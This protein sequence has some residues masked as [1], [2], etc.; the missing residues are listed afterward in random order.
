MWR[1]VYNLNLK[2]KNEKI[3]DYKNFPGKARG[4][5]WIEKAQEL[6]VSITTRS[7][8]GSRRRFKSLC[9]SSSQVVH[10]FI[11]YLKGN[12]VFI[13]FTWVT[14]R[15]VQRQSLHLEWRLTT[16]YDRPPAVNASEGKGLEKNNPGF[17]FE[18]G[19]RGVG[20]TRCVNWPAAA[21]MLVHDRVR[22]GIG[23]VHVQERT[24]LNDANNRKCEGVIPLMRMPNT[25]MK[26]FLLLVTSWLI[27]VRSFGGDRHGC[28]LQLMFEQMRLALYRKKNEVFEW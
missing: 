26:T 7:K 9:F 2:E 21:A 14:G 27:E 17:S 25:L 20:R 16:W 19:G 6:S 28:L 23:R 12:T 18:G 5:F 4:H 11:S 3:K 13:T 22:V 1:N 24:E 10:E 15:N 8:K